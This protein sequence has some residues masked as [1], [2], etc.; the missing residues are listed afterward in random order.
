MRREGL[1]GE[2]CDEVRDEGRHDKGVH[3]VHCVQA[4][5]ENRRDLKVSWKDASDATPAFC[6]IAAGWRIPT[7]GRFHIQHRQSM[8]PCPIGIIA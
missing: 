1:L 7:M 3:S 6:V 2:L 5:R 8:F 4:K